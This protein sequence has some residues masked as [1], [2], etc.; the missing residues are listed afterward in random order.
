MKQS[1]VGDMKQC[2]LS[3]MTEF[4]ST[5]SNETPVERLWPSISGKLLYLLNNF[6]PL[7]LSTNN[8]I[9]Y[10]LHEILNSYVGRNK[11]VTIVLSQ[12]TYLFIGKLLKKRNE[13]FNG[14]VE[15][16]LINTCSILFIILT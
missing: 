6:V 4:C 3:F 16:L 14:N 12:L 11:E 15:E 2:M 1:N 9:I 7:K 10:G 5:Y 8:F 13:K